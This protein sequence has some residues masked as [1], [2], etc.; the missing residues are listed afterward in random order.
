LLIFDKKTLT[1]HLDSFTI[2]QNDTNLTTNPNGGSKMVWTQ[3]ATQLGIYISKELKEK[4]AVLAKKEARS[5][6][7]MAVELLKIGMDQ[8]EKLSQPVE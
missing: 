5:L 8:K 6:S 4:L 7:N 2:S 1:K 3:D